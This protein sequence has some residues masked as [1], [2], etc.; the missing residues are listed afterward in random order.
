MKCSQRGSKRTISK[1]RE[2]VCGGNYISS[3]R[4]EDRGMNLAHLPQMAGSVFVLQRF[5]TTRYKTWMSL[6]KGK[7]F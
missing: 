4:R 3:E 2:P 6:D 5:R 7:H 1:R